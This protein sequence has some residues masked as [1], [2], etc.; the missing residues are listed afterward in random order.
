MGVK[1]FWEA[2]TAD[3]PGR[4][5]RLWELN[6]EHVAK[7]G[8]PMRIAVDA[9]IDVYKYKT[10]TDHVTA[11]KKYGGMNHPTR[12]LFYHVCHL[13]AAGVEPVYVYDGPGKPPIKRQKQTSA[14]G[15]YRPYTPSAACQLRSEAE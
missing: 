1:G 11:D 8:R 10:A 7:T 3:Y 6:A 14:P 13:L 5:V 12:T 4:T 15:P 9:P 2:V